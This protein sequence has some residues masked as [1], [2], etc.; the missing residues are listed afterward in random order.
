MWHWS[1]FLPLWLRF[2]MLCYS[3]ALNQKMKKFFGRIKMVLGGNR[4]II[5]QILIIWILLYRCNTWTLT[6]RI[7]KKF[8]ENYTRMLRTIQ[9]KFWKQHPTKQQLYDHLPL[10]SKVIEVR[11]TS[12]GYH[13]PFQRTEQFHLPCMA[14]VEISLGISLRVRPEEP[15]LLL[16]Y[17]ITLSLI[18]CSYY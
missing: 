16:K 9:N 13:L 2:I 3:T 10:I 4:S 8:D 11:R 1:K 14:V 17:I 18:L 15:F 6:K 7:G 12:V 5:S